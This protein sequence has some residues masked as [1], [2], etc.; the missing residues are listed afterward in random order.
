MSRKA[1]TLIELLVVIAIIAILA[2][3]LFPVFARAKEAAKKT[4]AIAQARQLAASVMLYA[5]D[6]DDYFVPAT[7]YPNGPE[8]RRI[9]PPLIF[10]Y[11]KNEGIF[12]APGT[13]AKYATDWNT[14]NQQNIGLNGA[15]AVDLTPSG[16]VEGQP[17]TAGCEGFTTAANFSQAEESARVALFTT[18]PHG[19][20]AQKYRGYVFSPYNGPVHPI[21]K[22]LSIPL[23]SDRDLVLELGGTLT[24]SQLKPI[25]MLYNQT[26]NNDGV[27]PVIFADGHTKSYSA[28][29]ILA[30]D[31]IFWRF[32]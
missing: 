10:P 2:A 13:D 12:V 19:P 11:V 22:K 31:H 5:A 29:A 27:S 25:R 24:P 7:I 8:P 32:R 3:I 26:G 28:K 9:W 21:E 16:C 4:S 20:L 14:R 30:M 23:T 15:T 1:F 17:N 6:Y 18:T